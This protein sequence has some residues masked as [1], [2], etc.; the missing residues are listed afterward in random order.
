MKKLIVTL[1]LL[2]LMVVPAF[3]TQSGTLK[4]AFSDNQAPT[5]KAFGAWNVLACRIGVPTDGSSLNLAAGFSFVG[6]IP[7]SNWQYGCTPL[8]ATTLCSAAAKSVASDNVFFCRG[9]RFYVEDKLLLDYSLA[10]QTT[11]A[12]IGL[13]GYHFVTRELVTGKLSLGG[14][15]DWR[16]G[17]DVYIGPMI[18]G[19]LS[20]RK[21][22]FSLVAEINFNS[23]SKRRLFG[24]VK[25]P[26]PI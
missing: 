12:T 23:L 22:M 7:A 9:N 20:N 4:F 8:I 13:S 18:E 15:V 25:I 1:V 2:T 16:W 24:E 11:P 6:N 21:A 26:I 3:A 17:G 10:T 14:R 19:H 5:I